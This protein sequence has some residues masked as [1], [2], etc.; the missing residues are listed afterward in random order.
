MDKEKYTTL[1]MEIIEFDVEDVI[2]SSPPNAPWWN[3]EGG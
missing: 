2:G 3:G 1:E